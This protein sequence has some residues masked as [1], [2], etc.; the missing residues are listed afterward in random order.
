M[1]SSFLHTDLSLLNTAE[2]A[3]MQQHAKSIGHRSVF[4][5]IY[6][7]TLD[8]RDYIEDLWSIKN[9]DKFAY[10]KA[11]DGILFG[12]E[13]NPSEV[14]ANLWASAGHFSDCIDPKKFAAAQPV[15]DKVMRGL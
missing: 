11:L 7:D 8:K 2:I 9:G 6:I 3:A 14:I 5:T 13:M 12:T 4:M 10:T 1:F 15:L